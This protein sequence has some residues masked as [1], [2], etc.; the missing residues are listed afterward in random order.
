[1]TKFLWNRDSSLRD[2]GKTSS[3]H[4]GSRG[5]LEP[6]P[7]SIGHK[8]GTTLSSDGNKVITVPTHSCSFK[9]ALI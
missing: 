7:G 1:M 5:N 4:N 6:I 3:G 8:A 9:I 2:R